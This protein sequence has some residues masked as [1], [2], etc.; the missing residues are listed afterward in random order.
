MRL[1]LQRIEL[2]SSHAQ[3]QSINAHKFCHKSASK[4]T[5]RFRMADESLAVAAYI[6][7]YW[8]THKMGVIK[9]NKCNLNKQRRYWG[10]FCTDIFTCWIKKKWFHLLWNDCYHHVKI[11]LNKTSAWWIRLTCPHAKWIL[12]IECRKDQK[13]RRGNCYVAAHQ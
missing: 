10:V 7:R 9:F 5:K 6:R 13:K 12:C 4:D 11:R 2:F 1:L 3:A 8:M